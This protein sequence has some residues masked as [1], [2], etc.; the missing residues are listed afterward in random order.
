ME[1]QLLQNLIEEVRET[2]RSQVETERHTRNSRRHLLEIKKSL[3]SGFEGMAKA[4]AEIKVVPPE[5]GEQKV[6]NTDEITTP[7]KEQK[8]V[9]QINEE[10]QQSE[11]LINAVNSLGDKFGEGFSSLKK[12][13]SGGAG[14]LLGGLGGLLSGAGLGGGAL[15]AGAGIL[16]AGGGYFLQQLN[17]FDGEKIKQNVMSLLSIKDEFGGAGNFFK[18]GGAFLLAMTGIG[19]GLAVFGAGSAIAGL[20]DALTDF[21]NPNWATSIKNNVLELLS[22]SDALG[23]VGNL[24]KEGGAFTLA[25]T[26]IGIGLGVFGAGSAVAG[27]TDAI[28]D[29]V[30]PNWAASI[31]NNVLTLLSIQDSLGG[32]TL[33][34]L[35]KGAVFPLAMLGISAG[36]AVFGAGSAVA[37]VGLF[38]AGDTFA[39]TIKDNVLTLLSI[40]DSLGGAVAFIGDSATFLLAMSGIAAGLGV[41]GIGTALVGIGKFA[42]GDDFATNIKTEVNTL[43]GMLDD[44][45]VSVGKAEEF[46]TVLSKIGGALSDFGGGTFVGAL[47]RAGAAVLDFLSGSDSPINAVM[48]LAD[49]KSDLNEISESLSE[50]ANSLDTFGQLKFDTSQFEIEGFVNDLEDAVSDLSDLDEEK[51]NKFTRTFTQLREAFIGETQAVP[52]VGQ[53]PSG[54]TQTVPVVEQIPSGPTP[55]Q[56]NRTNRT[57]QMMQTSAENDV[58]KTMSVQSSPVVVN[59][60]NN[61]SI[62]NQSTT[63]SSVSVVNGD[64]A[65]RRQSTYDF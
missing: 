18:E 38:S 37:G 64:Y 57:Q 52:V 17:D 30:N 23:G 53:I 41:F 31:K 5:V 46:K 12:E 45:N 36:L 28:T 51:F 65:F 25:M 39:Q 27:I 62:T 44:E 63:N 22:I 40:Q 14:G 54:G 1:E 7:P 19:I 33:E 24:L 56:T 61:A 50:I 9:E 55:L 60:P 29:F 10:R 20:S 58:A 42:A 35:G 49:R 34:L 43:L 26:G 15:L 11:N 59:A 2:N 3:I 48:K 47:G 16:A 32:G 4:I 8:T 21:V 13:S 6:E